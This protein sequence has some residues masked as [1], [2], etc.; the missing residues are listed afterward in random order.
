MNAENKISLER[1]GHLL[2]IG[3]NRPAKRNAFDTEML[4]QLSLAYGELEND[5][6]IRCAV[7][8]AEGDMFTAGLDLSQVAPQV[9]EKGVLTFP[10]GGMDPLDL[11]GTGRRTK[12][13]I[14]AVQGKCLTIGIELILA[15]D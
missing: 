11:N 12:P 14:I 7:L 9:V 1:R 3:L 10:E 6:S 2:L 13:L 5:D 8:F 4:D 15:A